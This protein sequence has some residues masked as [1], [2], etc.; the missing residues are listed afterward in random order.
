MEKLIEKLREK[1]AYFGGSGKNYPKIELPKWMR[2]LDEE[3]E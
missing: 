2:Q 3:E 1:G